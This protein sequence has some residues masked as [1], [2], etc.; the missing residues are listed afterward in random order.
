MVAW[1]GIEPP[2]RGFSD[3]P[4]NEDH[5]SENIDNESNQELIHDDEVDEEGD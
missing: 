2:T 3:G 4:G 1:D 5:S